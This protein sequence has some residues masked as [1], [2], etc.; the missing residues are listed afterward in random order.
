MGVECRSRRA[1]TRPLILDSSPRPALSSFAARRAPTPAAPPPL[2]AM[3]PLALAALFLACP[4]EPAAPQREPNVGIDPTAAIVPWNSPVRT[5]AAAGGSGDAATLEELSRAVSSG[6]TAEV[7]G[8]LRTSYLVADDPTASTDIDGF[9]FDALRLFVRAQAGDWRF[10]TAIRGD[11]GQDLQPY[12]EANSSAILRMPEMWAMHD[13]ADGFH[14]RVGRFRTP[15]L[16]SAMMEENAMV[17]YSRSFMGRLWERDRYQAGV[18]IDGQIG[19]FRGWAAIQNG[20]DQIGENLAFTLKGQWDILGGGTSQQFQGA[21][22]APEHLAATIGG[23]MHYDALDDNYSAQL[24]EARMTL[25]RWY[26]GYEGVDL[27]QGL[28]DSLSNSLITSYMVT[29]DLE[30]ALGFESVDRVGSGNMWRVGATYY[31]EGEFAKVQAV[32]ND[33]HLDD[34]VFDGD[35]FLIGVTVAF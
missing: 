34:T 31:L 28:F 29:D 7:H 5:R 18:Q 11:R 23:A 9:S 12:G 24:L 15:F 32:Y 3:S 26:L 22:N 16:T 27:G 35:S 1:P 8:Y 19:D 30:L 4:Q 10:H 20:Q 33:S 25:D 17:L 2:P 13:F 6:W 14:F 21:R